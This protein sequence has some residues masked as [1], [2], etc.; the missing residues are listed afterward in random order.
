M[1]DARPEHVL[2]IANA[3]LEASQ[4]A[5]DDH[6]SPRELL[7]A[8]IT[9]LAQSIRYLLERGVNEQELRVAVARVFPPMTPKV[10]RMVH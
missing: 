10:S 4:H 9:I 1:T 3:M 5:C 2:T 8:Q 7:S 6:T